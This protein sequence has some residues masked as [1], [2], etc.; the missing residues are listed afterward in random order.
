MSDDTSLL[1]KILFLNLNCIF[2]IC[3]C[4]CRLVDDRVVVEP[5][6]GTLETPP[7][8]YRGNLELF[9]FLEFDARDP[10]FTRNSFT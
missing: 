6:A 1:Q 5:K 3:N 10:W 4:C 9:E 8:K 2:H 7:T